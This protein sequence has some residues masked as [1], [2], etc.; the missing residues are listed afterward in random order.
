MSG[1]RINFFYRINF[2]VPEHHSQDIVRVCKIYVYRVSLDPK[3]STIQFYV[4]SYV[5]AVYQAT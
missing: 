3:I 4:I 2:I 1:N 5:K